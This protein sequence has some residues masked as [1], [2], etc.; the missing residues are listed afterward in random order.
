[1]RPGRKVTAMASMLFRVDAGLRQR[2]LN[3]R[4]DPLDVLAGSDLGTTP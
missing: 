3:H 1:M 4:L 2:V